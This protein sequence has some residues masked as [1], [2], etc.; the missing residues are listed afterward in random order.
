MKILWIGGWAMSWNAFLPELLQAFP[1]HDHQ[2]LEWGDWISAIHSGTADPAAPI[3][4]RSETAASRLPGCHSASDTLS[5]LLPSTTPDLV[6][7]WSQGVQLLPYLHRRW[8]TEPA[9]GFLLVAP[10]LDFCRPGTGWRPQI[11][12]RMARA[13]LQEP[14][15]VLREFATNMGVPEPLRERWLAGALKHPPSML[16]NGLRALQHPTLLDNDCPLRILQGSDDWIALP[17][18]VEQAAAPLPF[19]TFAT[20]SQAPHWLLDERLARPLQRLIDDAP[21]E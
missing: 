17:A 1:G 7:P 18:A 19:C 8:V 2:W 15:P 12:E 6:V 13:L 14:A 11:L 4:G 9:R 5:D 3:H 20:A 21:T 10:A 16:A